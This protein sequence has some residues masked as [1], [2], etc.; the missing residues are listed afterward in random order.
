MYIKGWD[1]ITCHQPHLFFGHLQ[2][3]YSHHPLHLHRIIKDLNIL[4][5]TISGK[6]TALPLLSNISTQIL[7]RKRHLKKTPLR[8][9]YSKIMIILRYLQCN[10][11]YNWWNGTSRLSVKITLWNTFSNIPHLSLLVFLSS[12]PLDKIYKTY[13]IPSSILSRIL[14]MTKW[15]SP[16]WW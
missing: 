4:V 15:G 11:E 1:S 10:E 14:I 6:N 2:G 9:P 7:I 5:C 12:T 13:T 16:L 8:C 3:K